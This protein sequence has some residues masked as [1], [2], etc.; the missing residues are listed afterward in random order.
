M[1]YES[2]TSA[3]SPWEQAVIASSRGACSR[4]CGE[5]SEG[6]PY[7]QPDWRPTATGQDPSTWFHNCDSWWRGWDGEDQ[8]HQRA[9]ASCTAGAAG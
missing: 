1:S 4:S 2:V 7:L 3:W 5:P 8:R 6:N 9:E